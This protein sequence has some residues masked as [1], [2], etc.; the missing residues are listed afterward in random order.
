[1]R[2]HARRP[3]TSLAAGIGLALLPFLFVAPAGADTAATVP[4][5]PVSTDPEVVPAPAWTRAY[6]LK[7]EANALWVRIPEADRARIEADYA[8]NARRFD[9]LMAAAYALVGRLR[10]VQAAIAAWQAEDAR[11]SADVEAFRARCA[12]PEEEEDVKYCF[13]T[14]AKLVARSEAHEAAR[15]R[16]NEAAARWNADSAAHNARTRAWAAG[17]VEALDAYLTAVIAA[18]R[19]PLDEARRAALEAERTALRADVQG[20]AEALRR[21]E[22]QHETSE[23]DRA[24][25]ER[26]HEEARARA[27]A[28]AT[29]FLTDTAVDAGIALVAAHAKRVGAEIGRLLDERMNVAGG[30]APDKARRIRELDEAL[31]ARFADRKALA[32]TGEGLDAVK[33][34]VQEALAGFGGATAEDRRER[35]DAACEA[36]TA[37]LAD[38]L[39]QRGLAIADTYGKLATY[40]KLA[41]DSGLDVATEVAA[42]VRV[43]AL[44]EEADRYLE[45]VKRL[46][47]AMKAKV[48]RIEELTRLLGDRAP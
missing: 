32:R 44:N 27:E 11:L 24:E 37:L 21:L 26:R 13:E 5:R 33:L 22:R 15:L 16:A 14:R 2:T 43:R 42:I 28:R 18:A 10:D 6:E 20:I 25:W 17:P 40:A 1:M 3:A 34:R 4:V 8:S 7:L 45:D 48:G 41:T 9:E 30:D 35:L 29:D 47:L 12:Q 36:L 46:D 31:A 39:V 38:P 19:A 23:G